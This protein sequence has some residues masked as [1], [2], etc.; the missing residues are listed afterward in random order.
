MKISDKE[1]EDFIQELKKPIEDSIIPKKSRFAIACDSAS[2]EH[3]WFSKKPKFIH[4]GYCNIFGDKYCFLATNE[5]DW[6]RVVPI[7]FRRIGTWNVKY[8]N[9]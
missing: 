9:T 1:L 8:K 7:M 2:I 4:V 3:C 5:G 6:D